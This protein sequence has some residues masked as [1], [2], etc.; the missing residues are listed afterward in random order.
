MMKRDSG[1]DTMNCAPS[2][3]TM[4][5]ISV[6]ENPPIPMIP[7]ESASCASPPIAPADNP[8]TGPNASAT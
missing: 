2:T 6:F 1:C 7:P 8:M 4:N 5:P 3:P